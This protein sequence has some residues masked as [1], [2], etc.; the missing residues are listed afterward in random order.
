M[1]V[2][3]SSSSTDGGNN[4]ELAQ[5]SSCF[6]NIP[7]RMYEGDKAMIQKLI[8]PTI[9]AINNKSSQKDVSQIKQILN[10][11]HVWGMGISL[12]TGY[13]LLHLRNFRPPID[14]FISQ[15]TNDT[16]TSSEASNASTSLEEASQLE[17]EQTKVSAV[18]KLATLR[19]LLEEMLPERPCQ[20]GKF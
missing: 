1:E 5:V 6:K 7:I 17:V 3:A 9:N 18:K 8:K 12:I 15:V 20:E 10:A 16:V 13:E 2:P 19:D 11:R 14:L 4:L